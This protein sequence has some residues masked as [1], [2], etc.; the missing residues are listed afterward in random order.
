MSKNYSNV[1]K[2]VIINYLYQSKQKDIFFADSECKLNQK[3]FASKVFKYQNE[4]EKI[5]KN[6]TKRGVGILLDRS[7]DYI[8][9]IFATWLCDGYYVPLS[10]NSP[11]KNINYQIN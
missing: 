4:L 8:A 3:Q 6:N 5:W 7:T 2:K 10:I 1:L 11:Q 9:I